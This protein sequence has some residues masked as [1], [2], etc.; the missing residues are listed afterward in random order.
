M[1]KHLTATLLLAA[2]STSAMA[3][4]WGIFAGLDLAKPTTDGELNGDSLS[5][6]NDWRFNGYVAIEHGIILLP[7]V[8]LAF[9]DFDAKGHSSASDVTLNLSSIDTT[10]YYQV[11]DNELFEIDLG[12]TLKFMDGDLHTLSN[13]SVSST[14]PLLYGAAKFHIPS[15]QISV[16]SELAGGAVTDDKASDALVGVGYTLNSEGML[17]I[18]LRGGYRYQDVKIKD[19]GKIKSDYSGA[20][21]GIEVNF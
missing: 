18:T 21:A 9:A 8:K 1:K 10:F 17:P 12:M 11:F 19:S 2:C 6:K 5:L 3:D 13:Q 16:F 20:F 15:T 4:D 14:I 7:N